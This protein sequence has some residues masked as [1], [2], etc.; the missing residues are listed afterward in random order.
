M[1][2]KIDGWT[3][4]ARDDGKA[5]VKLDQYSGFWAIHREQ[6]PVVVALCPC[7][8]KP[9]TSARAAKLVANHYWPMEAP[10]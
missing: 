4:D 9:F 7:C 6:T 5:T 2:N 3:G 10:S 1:N 8:N